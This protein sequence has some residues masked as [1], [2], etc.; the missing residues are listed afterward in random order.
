MPAGPR[1]SVSAVKPSRSQNSTVASDCS[2]A[3]SPPSVSRVFATSVG[4]NRPRVCRTSSLSLSPATIRLNERFASSNSVTRLG[5]SGAM[6][7][8]PRVSMARATVAR[9]R[10]GRLA[11]APIHAASAT[12]RM[13]TASPAITEATTRSNSSP[14]IVPDLA[15]E[16]LRAD[17]TTL[18]SHLP[19][20]LVPAFT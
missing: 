8:R 7:S 19:V 14:S 4:T 11:R 13:R 10:I 18:A 12:E 16:P 3:S 17:R 5:G 6:S 1:V 20:L 9:A 2:G 15:K